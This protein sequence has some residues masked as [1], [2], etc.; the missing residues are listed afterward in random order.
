M[1]YEEA[2]KN[3]VGAP[4]EEEEGAKQESGRKTV[5]EATNAMSTELQGRKLGQ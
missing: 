4:P 2:G 1:R 3:V 5:V